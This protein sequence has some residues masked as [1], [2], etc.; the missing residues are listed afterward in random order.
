LRCDRAWCDGVIN[1]VDE[2]LRELLRAEALNGSDVEIVLDAPTR[3]WAARR[4]APTLDMYL[5]DIHEDIRRRH[6]GPLP[7]MGADG[8]VQGHQVPARFL[9][10]S[11]LVTAWTQRPEDEHRLLAAVLGCFLKYDAVPEVYLTDV[12]KNYEIPVAIRVGFP[13]S[14]DRKV[15]DVWSSL[16]G[17]LKASLDIVATVRFEAGVLEEA[18][19]AVAA[20]LRLRAV[21]MIEDNQVDEPSQ[22]PASSVEAATPVDQPEADVRAPARTRSTGQVEG[23][24]KITT[25][26]KAA[27][28]RPKGT[29]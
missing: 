24:A 25:V 19:P 22:R 13:P 10:M 27:P 14:E 29:P 16:G 3:D 7:H 23:P 18:A 1:D 12:L 21:G 6:N 9:Q 28:R 5:Y 26:K 17:D 2:S 4:N 20:P 11:Y 8:R 15:S